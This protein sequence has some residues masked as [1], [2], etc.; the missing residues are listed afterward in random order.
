MFHFLSTD[1]DE[2]MARTGPIFQSSLQSQQQDSESDDDF[3][4]I[5]TSFG[6]LATSSGAG[7]SCKSPSTVFDSFILEEQLPLC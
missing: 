3:G 2:P 7:P 1:A 4:P 5:R 6:G